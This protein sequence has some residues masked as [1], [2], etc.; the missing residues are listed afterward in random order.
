MKKVLNKLLI[1]CAILLL[2]LPV[3]AASTKRVITPVLYNNSNGQLEYRLYDEESSKTITDGSISDKQKT[4]LYTYGKTYC[5]PWEVSLSSDDCKH[6]YDGQWSYLSWAS[7]ST[8]VETDYTLADSGMTLLV[9]SYNDVINFYTDWGREWVPYVDSGNRG[10]VGDLYTLFTNKSLTIGDWTIKL[11]TNIKPSETEL[12]SLEKTVKR[13]SINTSDVQYARISVT[14]PNNFADLI[15]GYETSKIIIWGINKPY[16]AGKKEYI[17]LEGLCQ[18]ATVAAEINEN[19][20]VDYKPGLFADTGAFEQFETV[21]A[22]E[23]AVNGIF[24]SITTTITGWAGFEEPEELIFSNKDNTY[25]GMMP[26]TWW[27]AS[28]TMFWFFE[29]IAILVLFASVINS[30]IK[31]SMASISPSIRNTLKDSIANLGIAIILL[32]LYAP[33]FYI[34]AKINSMLVTTLAS[35]ASEMGATLTNVAQPTNS[36]WNT[37]LK[38]IIELLLFFINAGLIIKINLDYFVRSITI[39]LLHVMAP[40]AIASISFDNRRTLFNNWLKELTGN[41]FMQSFNALVLAM[42][43]IVLKG[44]TV[45]WWYYQ[46]ALFTIASLNTWFMNIFGLQNSV[47]DMATKVQN[48]ASNALEEAKKGGLVGAAAGVASVGASM[49]NKGS[50][51]WASGGS[52]P[53]G[54]AD[55]NS[56]GGGSSDGTGETAQG[57]NIGTQIPK[58]ENK[59]DKKFKTKVIGPNTVEVTKMNTNSA[60][61][62]NTGDEQNNS[63]GQPNTN[64]ENGTQSSNFENSNGQSGSMGNQMPQKDDKIKQGGNNMNLKRA[65]YNAKVIA[66]TVASEAFDNRSYFG[67]KAN[68]YLGVTDHDTDKFAYAKKTAKEERKEADFQTKKEK[69]N[70]KQ[71]EDLEEEEQKER[72][73]KNKEIDE[74]EEELNKLQ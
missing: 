2:V 23:E 71:L 65:K 48:Q 54:V 73:R 68:E 57:G 15:K 1:L 51:N 37:I 55:G 35:F 25:L 31:Q 38:F 4:H 26:Q 58:N 45:H 69:N 44:G 5:R 11:E 72:E 66:A 29:V 8:S 18:Y 56:A 64:T 28:N 40:V 59:D 9:N 67:K 19:D 12:K 24:G 27:E 50:S 53:G 49:W 22:T 14:G 62:G 74:Y 61:S 10:S 7:Q 46:A 52:A 17:T 60:N 47:A 34:L 70:S 20:D 63:S 13:S 43:M 21:S 39:M 30:A 33:I 41:I 42:I 36:A 16:N 3:S 32:I 6:D